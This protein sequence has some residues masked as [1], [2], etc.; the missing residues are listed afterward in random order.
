MS[1]S[2]RSF[3]VGAATTFGAALFG[4]GYAI[5]SYG[6][7]L[8]AAHARIAQKSSLLRTYY[9]DLEYAIE[10]HGEP[11]MMVHGTGGGFDQ[12]LRFARG[13]ISNGFEV[14]AP[15]RFG[16]LRS[17]FPSNP[18]PQNQADAFVELLDEL[19]IDKIPIAGGSA[20][21]IPAA[22]FALRHPSRC[23]HLILIVPA[24]NLSDRDP[25]EFTQFQQFLIGKML[26][27]DR[28]FWAVQ[29][30]AP[31]QL[32][33][34]LLATDPALLTSVSASERER[35]YLVLNELIPISGRTQGMANDGK[36][37]GSPTDIDF[38]QI[39]TPTLIISAED[40]RFGT[41][42][43]SRII[44]ERIPSSKLVMFPTGGHL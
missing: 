42:Q 7:A 18:S 10:G 22:H 34:T 12:G 21:A 4:G 13:L 6:E 40:D 28:W 8:A 36:I 20:G 25:V 29:R 37:A 33:G 27:S 38:S 30:L 44:T 17:D 9:G 26:S 1:V 5:G 23:S 2:R 39:V 43:T 19:G 14:I 31:N 16:Y 15:S 11:F 32:I 3:V 35:A 24:M 41:A